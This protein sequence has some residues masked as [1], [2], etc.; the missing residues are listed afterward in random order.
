MAIAEK[1][2]QPREVT[3]EQPLEGVE[4]E[5]LDPELVILDE[6]TMT[7]VN[8]ETGE[9]IGVAETPPEDAPAIEIAKWVGEKRDWHRGRL[10]GLEAEKAVHLDKIAKVY[11]A[12]I[13]RHSRAIAWLEKQY[14]P[15]LF[16]LAKKLVGEGKKRSVAVGM[17][18]LKLRKTKPSVDV[19]DN[20]KAVSYLRWLIEEQDKKIAALQTKIT[21]ADDGNND[22]VVAV[23]RDDLSKET[24]VRDQLVA[25]LNV[26]TTVYKSSLPENLKS[27][28]TEENLEATGML[29]N[30][31]GEEKLEIE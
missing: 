17:L 27:K 29:F 9:V 31:G 23:Y 20:D 19:Q 10:A 22:D 24:L 4:V 1:E 16:E 25:C 26:K 2:I 6:E 30:P 15:M 3:D 5:G 11:D 8:T 7:L 21:K 12:R 18:I 28:L 14:S 13:N